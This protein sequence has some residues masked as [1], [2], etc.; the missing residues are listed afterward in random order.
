M[1]P[2][3]ERLQILNNDWHKG[4]AELSNQVSELGEK[5][6]FIGQLTLLN[7]VGSNVNNC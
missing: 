5:D 6:M 2:D 3:L 4:T 1:T 7:S